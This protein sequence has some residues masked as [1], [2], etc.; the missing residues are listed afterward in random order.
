MG[1]P[2]GPVHSNSRTPDGHVIVGGVSSPL[3]WPHSPWRTVEALKALRTEA[4][5]PMVF[6]QVSWFVSGQ[7]AISQSWFA[8]ETSVE[9]GVFSST[10]TASVGSAVDVSGTKKDPH[11]STIAKGATPRHSAPSFPSW[12]SP[13]P[14][15]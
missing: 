4:M 15:D 11:R 6:P 7:E 2:S 9:S 13:E 3:H 14:R 8:S 12:P 1:A 10:V 5:L